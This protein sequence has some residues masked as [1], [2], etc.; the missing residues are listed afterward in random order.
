ML[1]FT[2][3]GFELTSDRSF[4]IEERKRRESRVAKEKEQSKKKD[5]PA[6]I[7]T[8]PRPVDRRL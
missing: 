1:D 5:K 6:S 4:D 3:H 7:G 2:S 8:S